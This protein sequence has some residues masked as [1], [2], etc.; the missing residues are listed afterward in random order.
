MDYVEKNPNT[1]NKILSL[2]PLE[3]VPG[4]EEYNVD[5]KFDSVEEFKIR[6]NNPDITHLMVPKSASN[7]IHGY[8][9]EKINAGEYE[10]V[11]ENAEWKPYQFIRIR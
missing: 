3:Y 8:I 1:V 4:L 5:F 10:L 9:V 7:D 11:F 6:I 2:Y